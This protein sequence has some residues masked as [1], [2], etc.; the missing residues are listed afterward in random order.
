M[1]TSELVT[2]NI[3]CWLWAPEHPSSISKITLYFYHSSDTVQILPKFT[4][5]QSDFLGDAE[6]PKMPCS[7]LSVNT[8][9]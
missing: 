7:F 8:M 1:F 4:K 3:P 9:F 2:D 5:K 6:S